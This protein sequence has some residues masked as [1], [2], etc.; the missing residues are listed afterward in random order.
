MSELLD[1]E[2]LKPDDD[3]LMASESKSNENSI[4]RQTEQKP[5][6]KGGN[7][8]QTERKAKFAGNSKYNQVTPK[9]VDSY[10][11]KLE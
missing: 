8:N 9:R 7:S 4:S 3:D 11:N 2:G 1:V 6:P 5:K 10:D